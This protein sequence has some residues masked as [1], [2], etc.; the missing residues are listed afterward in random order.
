MLLL[1]PVAK[2]VRADAP[3]RHTG[4]TAPPRHAQRRR[5]RGGAGACLLNVV[6]RFDDD[7]YTSYTDEFKYLGSLLEKQLNDIVDIN[8][9][10]KQAKGQFQAMRDN[11]FT[12]KD[13]PL[14][15]QL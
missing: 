11:I 6:I 4:H 3:Q 14:P 15:E 8:A 5:A 2:A 1:S 10:I 9:R 13:V 7:R 12:N